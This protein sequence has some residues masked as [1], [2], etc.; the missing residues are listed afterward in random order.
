MRY[1]FLHLLYIIYSGWWKFILL[2]EASQRA[3]SKLIQE[4][5]K[6]QPKILELIPIYGA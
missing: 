3:F 4:L 5:K 2:P 6:F 1:S